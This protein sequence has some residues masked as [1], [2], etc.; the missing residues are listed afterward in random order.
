MLEAM[1][2]AAYIIF[3]WPIILFVIAG[4]LVG[5][6]F[7]A[8]PGVGGL[9]A[10]ALL[11]P[12]TMGLDA[13]EVM[14]LF[15]AI[16]GGVAFGGSITAILLNVPGTA[17]N[18]ATCLDGYPMTQKGEGDRAL[19]VSAVASAGG[20]I[21][22]IVIL[23]ALI[24]FAQA[25]ILSFGAPEFF[26]M[27]ILGI[28][29]IAFITEGEFFKGLVAGGLGFLMSFVGR[30]EFTAVPRYD[31]VEMFGLPVGQFYLYDGVKLVVAVIGMFAISEALRLIVR[32]NTTIAD[33][34]TV[35]TSA[36]VIAG[37]REVFRHKALFL[38]SAA[39][40]TVVGMVPAVG[41][42]VSTFIAYLRATQTKINPENFG[43]GDVRGVLAPEASNDAKDGGALL[44]TLAFGIPG[45]PTTAMILAALV[46]QGVRPGPTLLTRD[47][48]IVFSLIFALLLANM[49]TS[50]VGL[51]IANKI[52]KVAFM[53]TSYFIPI[54]LIVSTYGA[55]IY[56]NQPGDIIVAYFFGVLGL[57]MI[58]Y[59]YS[60][61]TFII[62]LI[63][64]PIAET[65]YHQAMAA[66]GMGG[67]IFFTRP[68]SLGLFLLIVLTF[69]YPLYRHYT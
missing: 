58:L 63:L 49:I 28:T 39:I 18:A 9:V 54:I 34:T 51:L 44:P 40:G 4:A 60:R 52:S 57:F 59:K 20:A 25:V 61:I 27:S 56:N 53:P 69:V 11:L 43:K 3:S 15:G 23:I 10:M 55:F 67:A 8:T 5:L 37:G 12:L 62:G 19:G 66:Y 6:V 46:L 42:A 33:P 13:A 7:G 22:G 47:L 2:E 14:A 50:S 41:G 45:S 24:P 16:L 31:A 30:S 21:V 26:M 68:I 65:T 36:G 48:Y 17:P 1:I 35:D 29:V 38:Q 32:K 64:G